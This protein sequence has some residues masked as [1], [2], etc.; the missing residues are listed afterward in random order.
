MPWP[1]FIGLLVANGWFL[2]P[3]A[4]DQRVGGPPIAQR[5][6]NALLRIPLF[7]AVWIAAFTLLPLWMPVLALGV[8]IAKI[9]PGIRM[10]NRRFQNVGPDAVPS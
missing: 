5:Q 7:V 4:F 8:W 10:L 9:I 2:G 3:V 1:V 6:R